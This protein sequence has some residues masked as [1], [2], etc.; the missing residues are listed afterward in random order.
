MGFVSDGPSQT[1]VPY[2]ASISFEP[3]ITHAAFHLTFDYYN[4]AGKNKA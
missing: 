3:E 2:A 1:C 4:L